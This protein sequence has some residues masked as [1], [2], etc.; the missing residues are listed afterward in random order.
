[1]NREQIRGVRFYYMMIEARGCVI[2]PWPSCFFH[3]AHLAAVAVLQRL[4]HLPEEVP[5][6][7]LVQALPRA[8]VVEQRAAG[9]VLH[10]HEDVLRP[11]HHLRGCT[12]RVLIESIRGFEI[13][14]STKQTLP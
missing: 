10:H 12:T 2:P 13:L 4:A 14:F 8:H 3:G 9:R 11:V 5:R 6:L 1:M 7:A